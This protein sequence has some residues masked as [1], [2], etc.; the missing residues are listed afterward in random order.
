MTNQHELLDA[1]IKKV[2]NRYL[3]TMLVAKRIRQLH[4]GAPAY[5]KRSEGE[6]HFT[7]A[8]RE[9]AEGLVILDPP[10]VIDSFAAAAAS[11]RPEDALSQEVAQAP[12]SAETVVESS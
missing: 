10:V 12:E 5:V 11:L 7:V 6:S 9:I 3:A 8:M 4:H 1:A 2:G